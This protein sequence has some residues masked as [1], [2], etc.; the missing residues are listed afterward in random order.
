MIIRPEQP[1]DRPAIRAV[2]E[3]AFPMPAEAQLVDQL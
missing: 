1:A 3:A 2:V